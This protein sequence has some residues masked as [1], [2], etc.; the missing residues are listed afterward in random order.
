MAG[1]PVQSWELV[2]CWRV[3]TRMQSLDL[4][5]GFVTSSSSC[6]LPLRL[7]ENFSA[8]HIY[9]TL[10]RQQKCTLN[11]SFCAPFMN[12]FYRVSR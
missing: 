9:N 11:L 6:L 8:V 4:L 7:V 3:F 10:E 1:K 12:N 5:S 2:F